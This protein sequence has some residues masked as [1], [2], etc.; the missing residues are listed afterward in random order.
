MGIF[1]T[2]TTAGIRQ[3]AIITGI[4]VRALANRGRRVYEAGSPVLTGKITILA[5]HGGDKI[6]ICG[7]GVVGGRIAELI[8]CEEKVAE[9]QARQEQW[10]GAG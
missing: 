4:I 1:K 9:F 5:S 8:I 10:E 7:P 3:I 2:R 6:S